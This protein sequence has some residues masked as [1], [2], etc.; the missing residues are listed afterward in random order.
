MRVLHTVLIMVLLQRKRAR[1]HIGYVRTLK[2]GERKAQIGVCWQCNDSD[3]ET[4]AY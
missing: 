1:M 4:G 2:I 3:P